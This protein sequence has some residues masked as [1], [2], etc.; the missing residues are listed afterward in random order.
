ME[1]AEG[2]FDAAFA[3]NPEYHF[4]W[5]AWA[6]SLAIQDR[7]KE[8]KQ[9]LQKAL[10]LDPDNPKIWTIFGMLF[11][12]FDSKQAEDAFRHALEVDPDNEKLV[13]GYGIILN[14]AGR[15]S[16]AEE[17]DQRFQEKEERYM[18]MVEDLEKM[19]NEEDI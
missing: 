11:M 4:T 16:E 15:H 5:G 17:Q 13:Y 18:R 19:E 14:Y 7:V 8:A 6:G 10:Q 1:E 12:D 2:C 3:L 9:A